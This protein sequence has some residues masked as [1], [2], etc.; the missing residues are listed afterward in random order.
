M[1]KINHKNAFSS[2]SGAQT[3]DDKKQDN[4][5]NSPIDKKDDQQKQ[6]KE[7]KEPETSELISDDEIEE[8]ERDLIKQGY[9]VNEALKIIDQ[10]ID[11]LK[12]KHKEMHDS[13]ELESLY[14]EDSEQNKDKEGKGETDKEDISQDDADQEDKQ[15]DSKEDI[16][17][18]DIKEAL[19]KQVDQGGKA[20]E[21][22]M[23]L[24]KYLDIND[25]HHSNILDIIKNLIRSKK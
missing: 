25:K 3:K 16:D 22:L 20:D 14:Q 1:K 12:Q 8:L 11:E 7:Y 19:K 24:N 23:L 21:I 9:S 10:Y 18:D 13:G 17:D 6:K 15:P 2:I 4:V 5:K